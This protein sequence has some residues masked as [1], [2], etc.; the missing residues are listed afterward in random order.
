[1]SD[2]TL[3][4]Q[5]N[6]MR[7]HQKYAEPW[8]VTLVSTGLNTMTGGRLLRVKEYIG[9]ETFCF[10]YGDGVTDMDISQLVSF[11]RKQKT[12]A[13]LTAVQ[14]PG[15]FGALV[16]EDNH[17]KQFNEKPK[18]DGTWIN[19]GYFV[20]EPEVMDLIKD[21]KTVWEKGPLEKLS[22]ENNLSVYQHKGFWAAMD[23]L[24]EKRYLDDLWQS[25]QA[26]WKIW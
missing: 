25:G 12:L 5:S 10:T 15:R 2:V 4:M 13:T 23:T 8:K 9:N 20:L 3:D 26:H 14:V 17:V 1:M 24:R 19:A 22:S 21:D 16:I 18:G 7:V 11:H 6:K